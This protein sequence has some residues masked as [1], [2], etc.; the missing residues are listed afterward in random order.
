MTERDMTALGG[1]GFHF[2]DIPSEDVDRME[3]LYGP[4]GDSVRALV[5]A[6]IRTEADADTIQQAR[7]EIDAVTARLRERQSDGPFGIRFNRAGRAWS[8]GNAA[9]GLRNAVAPPLVIVHGQDGLSHTDFELGAAYEG[10]PGKVH[11]GVLALVL[12]HLMGETASTGGRPTATGT[13]TLRYRQATPLGPL[14][15]EGRIDRVEGLKTFVVAHIS[16]PEGVTVE[17]DGVF[18]LPRWARDEH[19]GRPT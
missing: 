18:I 9:V 7:S 14:R 8:W 2:E 10:P 15:A 19:D 11:G 6:V 5:D 1:N 16:G 4:L 17:A 12:D 3:A 13:L